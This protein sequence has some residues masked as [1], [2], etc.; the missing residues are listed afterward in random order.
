MA[1]VS[2]NDLQGWAGTVANPKI[3]ATDIPPGLIDAGE[4]HVLSAVRDKFDVS[5]WTDESDTPGFI[6]TIISMWVVGWHYN[7]VY[8]EDSSITGG[9]ETFGDKLINY[10]DALITGLIDGTYELDSD[11]DAVLTTSQPSFWP[12]DTATT[13]A[14]N[15]G[16]DAD[17]AAV[18]HFSSGMVF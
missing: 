4:G 18:R 15:S 7:S 1:L 6:R 13:V 2:L 10:A 12:T 14:E 5:T 8:N 17:G 11:T 9:R 16:Q 3:K